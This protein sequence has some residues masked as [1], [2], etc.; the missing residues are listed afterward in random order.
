LA[1]NLN[2]FSFVRPFQ[3][4][5]FSMPFDK[6][7]QPNYGDNEYGDKKKR[8][9]MLI[10]FFSCRLT[11]RYQDFPDFGLP[12]TLSAYLLTGGRDLK[13]LVRCGL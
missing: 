9:H 3:L 5:V 1:T 2:A 12:N 6:E 13:E 7:A 4:R 8:E 10:P 11:F